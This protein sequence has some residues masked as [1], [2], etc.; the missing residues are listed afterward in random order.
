MGDP[1]EPGPGRSAGRFI[2]PVLIA[3]AV[4]AI[5]VLHLTGVVGPAR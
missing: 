4:V 5:L 3:L 1:R 2:V